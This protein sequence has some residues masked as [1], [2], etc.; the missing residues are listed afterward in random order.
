M[1]K[2]ICDTEKEKDDVKKSLRLGEFVAMAV[3]VILGI[4]VEYFNY[5]RIKWKVKEK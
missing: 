2:V 5:R 1:V 3:D 4:K